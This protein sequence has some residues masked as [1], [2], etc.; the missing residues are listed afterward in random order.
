MPEIKVINPVVKIITPLTDERCD[1][2]LSIMEYAGRTCYQSEAKGEPQK[3]VNG[4]VKRGHESVIEH[5]SITVNFICDRGVSHELVRHRVAAYS[6]ESTR[7]VKYSDGT[8]FIS[9]I[10]YHPHSQLNVVERNSLRERKDVWKQEC[11][12]S[13]DVYAELLELGAQAQEARAV[14]NNSLKTS[15]VCTFNMREWRHVFTMRCG[16]PA[17]PHIREIMIPTLMY[18]KQ[19]FPGMFD[20]IPYDEDFYTKYRL[21]LD[22]LVEET[23]KELFPKKEPVIDTKPIETTIE[24][25]EP[26]QKKSL[27]EMAVEHPVQ[28]VTH[29]TTKT[30]KPVVMID[31]KMDYHD[32]TDLVS[33]DKDEIWFHKNMELNEDDHQNDPIYQKLKEKNLIT[34]VPKIKV[35]VICELI[36]CYH[37]AP[38]VGNKPMEKTLIDCTAKLKMSY[39]SDLSGM[40]ITPYSCVGDNVRLM[41][42]MIVDKGTER[43]VLMK[44]AIEKFTE[45]L[46]VQNRGDYIP[47]LMKLKLQ[48]V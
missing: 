15:I 24:L 40:G 46:C 26:E 3:F 20:D 43:S 22:G 44:I 42:A 47:G 25:P 5:C 21:H 17:H 45:I 13:A 28:P 36:G 33:N 4:I 34:D 11:Q 10:E 35:V 23:F 19:K 29:L 9:M 39:H 18:F 32:E 2:M 12:R 1:E 41:T 37:Y 6:Q 7:Y 16:K 8:E 30:P 27:V 14:L 38:P 31:D 48:A